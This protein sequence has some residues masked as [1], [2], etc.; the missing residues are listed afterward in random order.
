[1]ASQKVGRTARCSKCTEF[2]RRERKVL[3]TRKS[4][5]KEKRGPELKKDRG[6]NASPV[7][8]GE[9]RYT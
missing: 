6:N 2:E 8:A 9:R 4:R 1:V 7:L 3:G 5:A